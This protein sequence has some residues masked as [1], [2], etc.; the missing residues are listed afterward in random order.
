VIDYLFL[1]P[2][3]GTYF[4]LIVVRQLKLIIDEFVKKFKVNKNLRIVYIKRVVV[5]C[6]DD[7]SVRSPD[8][9]MYSKQSFVKETYFNIKQ[10][11][12]VHRSAS[13]YEV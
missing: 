4:Y 1:S 2:V 7:E 13:L 6:L 10:L 11:L 9:S 8:C 12:Q 5:L 3:E